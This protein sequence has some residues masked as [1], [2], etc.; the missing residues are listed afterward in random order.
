MWLKCERKGG[1]QNSWLCKRTKHLAVRLPAESMTLS[2][3]IALRKFKM[4][5]F[6]NKRRRNLSFGTPPE[7]ITPFN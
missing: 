3:R 6:W 4:H 7:C 2:I 5:G 1:I